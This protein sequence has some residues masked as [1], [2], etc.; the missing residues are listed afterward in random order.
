[1]D[2]PEKRLA[3]VLAVVVLTQRRSVVGTQGKEYFADRA[4]KPRF[5]LDVF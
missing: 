2:H 4:E 3:L 5:Y 1:V